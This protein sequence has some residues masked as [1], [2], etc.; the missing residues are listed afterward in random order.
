M[1]R[2]LKKEQVLEIKNL[3]ATGEFTQQELAERF[4]VGQT[5]IS[6]IKTGFRW[7]SLEANK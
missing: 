6:S 7:G 5:T 4:G 3:L 2:K 1:P